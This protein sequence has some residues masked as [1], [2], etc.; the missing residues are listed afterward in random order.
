MSDEYYQNTY[1]GLRYVSMF[2]K[3]SAS[4]H[5]HNLGL[6]NPIVIQPIEWGIMNYVS[7]LVGE[8]SG[9]VENVYLID[10]RGDVSGFNAEGSFHLSGLV[11]VNY[12]TFKNSFISK[13]LGF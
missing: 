2:S 9:L 12:G 5:I 1:S 10:N 4:A 11:S 6:I 8:N 7:A 13:L 3:I